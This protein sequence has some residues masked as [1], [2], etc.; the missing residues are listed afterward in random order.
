MYL[1]DVNDNLQNVRAFYIEPPLQD[2]HTDEDTG[3]EDSGGLIEDLSQRQLLASSSAVLPYG[4]RIRC[5]KKDYAQR[6][7]AGKVKKEPLEGIPPEEREEQER[8]ELQQQQQ[9]QQ[10]RDDDGEPTQEKR[11]KVTSDGEALTDVV[12]V[13]DWQI[14]DLE[15]PA[16]PE[17]PEADIRNYRN[18][19]PAEMFELFFDEDMYNLIVEETN[20]YAVYCNKPDPQITHLEIKV[21]LGILMA[22]GYNSTTPRQYWHNPH[23]EDNQS[24]INAMDR[25]RFDEIAKCLHFRDN[26]E[27]DESDKFCKVKPFLDILRN[28]FAKYFIPAQNLNYDEKLIE[29]YGRHECKQPML[30]Y[31]IPFG[32]QVLTLTSPEGY[33]VSFEMYQSNMSEH[34]SEI[35]AKFGRYTAPLIKMLDSFPPSLKTLPFR[36]YFEK[37]FN[38]VPL[39]V[40]LRER[41]YYGTGTIGADKVPKECQLSPID[42]IQ[43]QVMGTYESVVSKEKQIV[44]VRM[45]NNSC[46]QTAA[47]SCHGIVPVRRENRY[48]SAARKRI[49]VPLPAIFKNFKQFMCGTDQFSQNLSKHRVAL[50]ERKWWWSIF[51]WFLDVSIL[52]AWNLRKKVGYNQSLLDFR[53]EI[54]IFYL[55]GRPI[56]IQPVVV[57]NGVQLMQQQQQQQQ[58]QVQQ[59][60][61][62]PLM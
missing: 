25:D 33:L 21:F 44:I 50:R 59:L 19:T 43:K 14:G 2:Y 61:Q 18:K 3:A 12:Y 28:N 36:F 45:M 49:Q 17:F 30:K 20:K 1:L 60:Q 13:H 11:M 26:H 22:S 34:P 39:L 15:G 42:K 62:P 35:E 41:G 9:Q 37:V 38:S 52:N 27:V 10:Q 31:T 57:S 5:E 55:T 8:L 16:P 24:I 4:E 58:Q 23:I 54:A 48:S 40:E 53:R 46:V 51:T 47:S 56:G 7:N 32:Y 6:A 29:Y